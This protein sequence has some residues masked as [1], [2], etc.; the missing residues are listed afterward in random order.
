MIICSENK[1][2]KS[3]NCLLCCLL[4]IKAT[5]LLIRDSGTPSFAAV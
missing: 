5:G 4:C 3:L 1:N 2:D